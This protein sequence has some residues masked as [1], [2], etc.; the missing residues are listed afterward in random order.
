MS[1]S[2]K[3][4]SFV[5]KKKKYTDLNFNLSGKETKTILYTDTNQMNTFKGI[6]EGYHSQ[7]EGSFK[8][9]GFDRVN[10]KWTKKRVVNIKPGSKLF[11][12]WPEKFWLFGTLLLN[13]SF[14]AK[15]KQNYL[16]TKYSYLNYV[17]AK[18]NE[19]DLEMR[20]SIEEIVD[21]FVSTSIDIE[22]KWLSDF[23]DQITAFNNKEID[24][25]SE[26]F[27]VSLKIIIK[28]YY[29]LAEKT[30]NLKL[31]ETFLESLWDK[32]YSFLDLHSS[33]ACEYN[34]KRS[35]FKS[36]RKKA[37]ELSFTQ[38]N[39]VI[40]KRLKIIDIKVRDVKRKLYHNWLTLKGLNKQIQTEVFKTTKRRIK[41]VADLFEWTQISR[42]QRFEFKKKQEKMYYEALTDEAKTI[43]GKIVER[44]HRYHNKLLSGDIRYG[45]VDNYKVQIAAKKAKIQTV[46]RQASQW[47]QN[48]IDELQISF[49]FIK[50]TF[51]WSILN[52]VY[53][54]LL[55]A[56]YLKQRNII[57][58]DVFAKLSKNEVSEV[59]RATEILKT[60]HPKTGVIFF[61]QKLQN[62]NDLD[63]TF[64]VLQ[65][66][67][68][69]EENFDSL[70]TN[71]FDSYGSK[72]LENKNQI[73]YA[74]D[75][76]NFIFN[77][78]KMKFN[79]FELAPSG[80]VVLNPKK[81][82][83][84]K[85][86]FKG[87]Y[88]SVEVK[89]VSTKNYQDEKVKCF[90]DKHGNK[91]LVISKQTLEKKQ[92]LYITPDSILRTI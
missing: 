50:T 4:A 86:D 63:E 5:I 76:K 72:F 38:Q 18:N 12:K 8:I 16:N 35:K 51:K 34:S 30:E 11:K 91:Y 61:E 68:I 79:N 90:S 74:F 13:S 19:T 9:D 41:D 24:A 70:M 69:I 85:S 6:L 2:L 26:E 84:S 7:Y 23:L 58:S 29:N 40:R 77:D 55:Q 80:S 54:K 92:K 62:L 49:G 33:C 60:T 59:V 14:Y 39:Y 44:I 31:L 67:K 82:Y 1:I 42:D 53:F 71:H 28:D 47:I 52:T 43:R 64:Y 37:K 17:S 73:A 25:S 22:V 10:R 56:I 32:V 45:D 21:K 36:I 20:A 89:E 75:G 46:Y 15:A 65:D 88:I 81:V 66:N 83:L 48:T 87:D 78:K 27:D 3:K 57:F